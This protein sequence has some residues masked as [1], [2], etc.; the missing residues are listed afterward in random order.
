MKIEGYEGIC[1]GCFEPIREGQGYKFREKG[2]SFHK[3]C[4]EI[5]P[6]DYYIKLEEFEAR[7]EKAKQNELPGLMTELELR[8]HI[9]IIND[10]AFN[11]DNEEVM[12]LY[13][14]ISNAREL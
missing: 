12:K 9:P 11:R 2:R 1:A 13:R 8:Y 10:E 3:R 7:F 6:R 5:M 14:R 4:V